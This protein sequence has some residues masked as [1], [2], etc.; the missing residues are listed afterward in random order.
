MNNLD[1]AIKIIGVVVVTL[2]AIGMV[3][4]SFLASA[5]PV[6]LGGVAVMLVLYVVNAFKKKNMASV[7][8]ILLLVV[9]I[10]TVFWFRR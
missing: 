1:K 5:M 6:I 4:Q 10:L 2:I 7:F 3:N 9:F 8:T